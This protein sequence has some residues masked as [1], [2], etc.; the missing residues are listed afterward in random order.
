MLHIFWKEPLNINSLTFMNYQNIYIYIY[1][2]RERESERERER[3][4]EREFNLNILTV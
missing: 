3:E 1:I 4:R 2:E